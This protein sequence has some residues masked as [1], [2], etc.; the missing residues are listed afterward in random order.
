MN[1][2]FLMS[3]SDEGSTNEEFHSP[4]VWL[5]WQHVILML[6]SVCEASH[7]RQWGKA[8]IERKFALLRQVRKLGPDDPLPVLFVV[9][10]DHCLPGPRLMCRLLLEATKCD[11]GRQIPREEFVKFAAQHRVHSR[12]HIGTT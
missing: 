9:R 6:Y 12:N 3:D 7:W 5:R 8:E 11:L 4:S 1:L 2:H 10:C